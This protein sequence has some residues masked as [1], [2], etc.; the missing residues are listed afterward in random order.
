[1]Y[2][3]VTKR[4]LQSAFHK[5]CILY[6]VNI[7]YFIFSYFQRVLILLGVVA[8]SISAPQGPAD[9]VVAILSQ[10]FDQQPDGSYRYRYVSRDIYFM[11]DTFSCSG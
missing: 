9:K 7:K 4:S 2:L 5:F 3:T 6:G 1:M 8:V 11:L 10:E